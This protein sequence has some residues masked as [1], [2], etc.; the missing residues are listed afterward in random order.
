MTASASEQ[1][2]SIKILGPGCANCYILEG[3]A[4]AAV[5]LLHAQKPELFE[6]V[7]V[8]LEHLSEQSDFRKYGVLRTPGLVVNEKL[9]AAGRLPG[10][11]EIISN[12]ER[13]LAGE[14][15]EVERQPA[16]D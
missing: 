13:T 5:Q 4:I 10:V 16:A 15:K 3:L 12:L 6:S 14:T 2:L 9:L 7:A 8:A 1:R 11:I